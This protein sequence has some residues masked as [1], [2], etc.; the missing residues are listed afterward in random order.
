M[1]NHPL[2]KLTFRPN[3]ESITETLN[4]LLFDLYGQ[5]F[6]TTVQIV[7]SSDIRS[8]FDSLVEK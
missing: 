6:F 8:G 4:E 1:A 3:N 2:R 7:V 5:G